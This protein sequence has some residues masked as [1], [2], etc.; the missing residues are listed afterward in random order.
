VIPDYVSPTYEPDILGA[1]IT[2]ILVAAWLAS[3]YALAVWAGS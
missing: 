3:I 2:G 1:V